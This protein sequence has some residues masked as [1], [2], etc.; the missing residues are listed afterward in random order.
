MSHDTSTVGPGEAPA[1][2]RAAKFALGVGFAALLAGTL[3][4]HR[5]PADGYE[6]SIYAATPAAYWVGLAAALVASAGVAVFVPDRRLLRDAAILLAGT[7]IASLVLLPLIRGYYY[8]GAG[9]SLTHL[10]WMRDIVAGR[11]EPFELLYPG[12]H[13]MGIFVA[14]LLDV[15]LGLAQMYVVAAFVLAFVAF[16]ALTVRLLGRTRLALFIGLVAGLLLLPNNNVSVHLMAHPVTQSLLLVP[17]V[18]YLALLYARPSTDAGLLGATPV[19]VLLS[20]VTVALVVIHPQGAL[21]VLLI[22]GAIS[23]VQLYVRWSD[24]S[25]RIDDH[26]PLYVPTLVGVVAFALW[27]PRFDRVGGAAEQVTVELIGGAAPTGDIAQRSTSLTEIGGSILELFV[28]LFL[29]AAV[30]GVLAAALLFAL[31]TGRLAHRDSDREALVTYVAASLIPLSVAFA[32]FFVANVSTQHFRYLGFVMV[33]V[34]LLGAVAL[35]EWLDRAGG[36]SPRWTKRLALVVALLLL[37]P[38]PLATLHSSP[39][40]YQP[41]PATTEAELTG[42]E[43][44]FEQMDREIG[45][46]GIRGGPNRQLDAIHGTE[47]SDQMGIDGASSRGAIP[48]GVFGNNMT[49]HYNESRYL[50]VTEGDYEREVSLYDG[51]RYSE[52]GFERLDATVGIDRVHTNGGYRLYV[53]DGEEEA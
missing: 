44:T 49:S 24:A 23:A 20:L 26:R 21:N 9:D 19:G 8:F 48:Y 10:G 16:V 33:P 51:L 46:I 43:A 25:T 22:L 32:F 31:Y 42:Y 27:A 7:S 36:P 6:L 34:T 29:P 53:V 18:L 1:G 4:A 15:R 38:M 45:F 47:R 3:I 52:R 5:S 50:P 41:T 13:T 11:L 14:R 2:A 30:F 37:L 39:F 12:I 40:I 17:L 35:D 28:K